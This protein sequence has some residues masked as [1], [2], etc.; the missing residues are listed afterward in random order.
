MAPSLISLECLAIEAA[1]AGVNTGNAFLFNIFTIELKHGMDSNKSV[2][3]WLDSSIA[4]RGEEAGTG[5]AL[6]DNV[7]SRSRI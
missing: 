6:L 5:R 7:G 2:L 1:T 3:D 4:M